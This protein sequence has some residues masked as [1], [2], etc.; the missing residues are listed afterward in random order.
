MNLKR[1]NSID[2]LSNKKI[3]NHNGIKI[4]EISFVNKI[5]LRIDPNN[6]E[7]MKVCGK[8]LNTILPVKPNT[9][10]EYK[11]LRI[12]WQSPD[13]WLI[14][15]YDNNDLFINLKKALG[16]SEASVTDVSENR[17]IFNISGIKLF[18]LLSK[19]M[20]L[21]F[22][23]NLSNFSSCAQTLFVKVPILI[24]RNDNKN[25]YPDIDILSNKSHA[26]Y[27]YNLIVDGAQNL[28]F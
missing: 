25:Q 10:S 12:L 28:D 20:V 5:N 17:T 23:K 13:E 15:N 1:E 16:N 7:H 11:N 2:S 14:I 3:E 19:F 22:E 27:I 21:D 18:K 4:K 24:I 8:I 26:K 9:Y 6:N